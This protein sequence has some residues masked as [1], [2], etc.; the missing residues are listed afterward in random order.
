MTRR[1]RLRRR[2]LGWCGLNMPVTISLGARG[3]RCCSTPMPVSSFFPL[4][5]LL[6]TSRF[7]CF[8]D[9]GASRVVR[10]IHCHP[11]WCCAQYPGKSHRP[12]LVNS[13][14]Y[15]FVFAH[16]EQ[17]ES[18]SLVYFESAEYFVWSILVLCEGTTSLIL[19]S[20]HSVK[21]ETCPWFLRAL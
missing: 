1:C 3:L 13:S 20:A 6:S 8:P 15:K 18:V 2:Q 21:C 17:C 14:E 9:G 5:R 10:I 12:R 11:L 19:S 7:S 16:S 4:S